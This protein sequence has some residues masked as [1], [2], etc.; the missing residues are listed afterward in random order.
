MYLCLQQEERKELKQ[1]HAGDDQEESTVDGDGIHGNGRH[2][3]TL[4][5]LS[6]MSA[7]S[8]SV[9]SNE[10]SRYVNLYVLLLCTFFIM[11]CHTK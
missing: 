8:S 1:K 5:Q 4:R 7:T 6:G 11:I 9:L 10:V 2:S 3:V